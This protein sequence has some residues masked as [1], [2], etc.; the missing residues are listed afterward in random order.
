M[1][2]IHD[3]KRFLFAITPPFLMSIVVK[4]YRLLMGKDHNQVYKEQDRPDEIDFNNL[5]FRV[6]AFVT[7]IA[8]DKLRYSGGVSFNYTQHHFMQYY[9]FGPKALKEFYEEHQPKTIFEQHFLSTKSVREQ[10]HLPWIDPGNRSDRLEHGLDS[11]HGHQARGPVSNKKLMVEL[12]RLGNCSKSIQKKG[13]LIDEGFPRGYFLSRSNGEWVFHV[14][15]GKH[16][17]A[18][19][20]HLGWKVIPICLEPNW[21]VIISEEEIEEWPGVKKGDYVKDEAQQ[22][23]DSYFRDPNRELWKRN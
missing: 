16:R 17:V 20:I 7:N 10:K 9:R 21:P 5:Y 4:V 23:F 11:S 22:V 8:H 2:R 18:A 13:Y 12:Q 15:G 19:L 6:G 1:I 14:V 3:L